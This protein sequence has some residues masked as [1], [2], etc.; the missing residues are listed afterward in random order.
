MTYTQE[1]IEKLDS[2]YSPVFVGEN[3]EVH[4]L[5]DVNITGGAAVHERLSGTL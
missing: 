5:P 4:F 1:L 3:V 2:T